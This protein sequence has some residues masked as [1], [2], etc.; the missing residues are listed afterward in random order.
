MSSGAHTIRYTLGTEVI[1][2]AEHK[3]TSYTAPKI[4]EYG[5]MEQLTRCSD[6]TADSIHQEGAR[7]EQSSLSTSQPPVRR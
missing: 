5:R 3:K 4:V 2:K 7:T 6:G 1:R